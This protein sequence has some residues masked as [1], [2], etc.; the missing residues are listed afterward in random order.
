[1]TLGSMLNTLH[2][3]PTITKAYWVLNGKL[4]MLWDKEKKQK[5]AQFLSSGISIS[6]EN[7]KSAHIK[8]IN[9]IKNTNFQQYSKWGEVK[10]KVE[11]GSEE[12]KSIWWQEV[13]QT[14]KWNSPFRRGMTCNR[15]NVEISTACADLFKWSQE[16][17]SWSARA[18]VVMF[19]GE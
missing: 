9:K 2:Q 12:E 10:P 16:S 19:I 14:C 3:S 11:S 13:R 18:M 17:I 1:M 5:T 7:I 8:E 6:S 4:K 15:Q